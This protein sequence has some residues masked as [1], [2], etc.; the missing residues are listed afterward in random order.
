MLNLVGGALKDKHSQ[1]T[2][3]AQAFT[4]MDE[5]Q[6]RPQ[7]PDGQRDVAHFYKVEVNVVHFGV[8]DAGEV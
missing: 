1:N 7:N 4:D 3:P 2:L 8:N 5:L 6:S